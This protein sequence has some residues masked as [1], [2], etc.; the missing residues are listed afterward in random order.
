MSIDV[1][2]VETIG[3]GGGGEGGGVSE[4]H[5]CGSVVSRCGSMSWVHTYPRNRAIDVFVYSI[6]CHNIPSQ[7]ADSRPGCYV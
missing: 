5:A 3:G 7:R 6:H 2:G 4:W 1:L